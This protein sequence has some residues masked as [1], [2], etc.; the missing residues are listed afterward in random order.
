MAIHII[1]V[2]QSQEQSEIHKASGPAVDLRY[3]R[4]RLL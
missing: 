1:R 3:A 4:H 2:M